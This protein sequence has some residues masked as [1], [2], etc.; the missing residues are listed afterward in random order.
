MDLTAGEVVNRIRMRL[1]AGARCIPLAQDGTGHY[2][3]A[4]D[5][6]LDLFNQYIPCKRYG[7]LNVPAGTP[8][9]DIDLSGESDLISVV[10]VQFLRPR[11]P[12]LIVDLG[13]FNLTGRLITSS[14]FSTGVVSAQLIGPG[15]PQ[16]TLAELLAQRKTV[17]RVRSLEPG[18]LW[19]PVTKHLL[20]YHPAGPYE[21]CYVKAYPHT[22]E[23]F[24]SGM[25]SR[26]LDAVEGYCRLTLGDILGAFGEEI[27][28]PT[29]PIRVDAEYQRT[30]GQQLIDQ[31]TEYLKRFPVPAIPVH[32]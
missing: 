27:P 32:G 1:G 14:P 5:R 19:D 15:T 10:S 23:T 28:G 13:I 7:Y 4:I 9:S 21:V 31:V 11:S 17:E 12:Q 22:L 16:T 2:Q 20:L 29:G 3:E 18:W 24:P 30:R 8:Q 26:F 6:A 25:K